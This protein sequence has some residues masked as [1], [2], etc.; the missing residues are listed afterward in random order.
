M[1]E[2]SDMRFLSIEY[3]YPGI[4]KPIFIDVHKYAYMVDNEILSP[5]FIKRFFDHNIGIDKDVFRSEYVLKI[6]DNN[7][8]NFELKS[9]QYILLQ[10]NSYVIKNL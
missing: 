7:L 8:N 4:E 10:P 3:S 9:D 6:M 1:F 5:A 2:Q